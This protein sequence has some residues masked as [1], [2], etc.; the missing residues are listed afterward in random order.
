MKD[1]QLRNDTKLLFRN[2][3]ARDL[4]ELTAGKKVLFVYGGG[5]VK[6]NGCYD[7][8]KNAIEKSG[9]TL[10]EAGGSSRER[11][12]VEAGMRMAKENQV[13]LIIGAGGASV[14]DCAKLIAFGACHIEDLWDFVKG[15]KNP[16]GLKK[17]PLLLMPTYPS[18]G[19]EYGLG[20]V[21]V[22]SKTGDF[23]TAYG[24]A[25]D[26]AVLAPKYS[27]SLGQEM[28]FIPDS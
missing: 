20:A 11:T 19:F 5:S 22:D 18:S 4:Q 3:T 16:Y 28:T 27:L 14:M 24:I 9:G 17:L 10:Y 25:A 8:V 12:A 23:G 6:K 1:F 26:Y 7:D 15:K 2:D 13:D 21:S